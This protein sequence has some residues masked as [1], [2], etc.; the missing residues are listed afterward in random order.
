MAGTLQVIELNGI[1]IDLSGR[2]VKTSTVSASPS[3]SAETVVATTPAFDTSVPFVAGVIVMANLAYTLGTSAAS[4]TVKLRQTNV[5]GAT[6]Y[7]TGAQTGGHNTATQLVADDV[8]AFDASPASGQTYC[9]TLTV[10]SGAA[11]STVSAV[12]LI[13]IA[14]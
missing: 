9:V 3:G 6:L 7:S 13:A 10:G 4:C 14:I 1:S 2:V 8:M 11:A 5:S 12:Q